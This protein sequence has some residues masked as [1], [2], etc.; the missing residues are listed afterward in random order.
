MRPARASST[1]ARSVTGENGAIKRGDFIVTSSTA[2]HAMK[3]TDTSRMFGAVIGK[4]LQEFDGNGTGVIL[5]LVNV[6]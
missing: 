2:G 1:A 5:V 6:R 3:G 4:A